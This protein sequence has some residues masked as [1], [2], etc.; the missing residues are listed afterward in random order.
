MGFNQ[1]QYKIALEEVGE[2]LSVGSNVPGI[3]Q[4]QEMSLH[5]FATLPST[6]QTLW[7][8]LNQGARHG[9]VVIAAQQT[10]GRGQWGRQWES[11]LGGLYLSVALTPQLQASNSAQLTMSSAWG[12]ATAL[13]SYDIPVALKWPNDLL[14]LGRKLGGIL[15]ETRVHQGEITKAVVGVGINWSNRVPE[16]GI[17]LQSFYETHLSTRVTSL[18]VLAAIVIQGLRLG[19]QRWLEQGIESLLPSYLEFLQIQGRQ[20]IVDGNPGIITGV[21]PI[22]DLRICLNSATAPTEICLK[23]GTIS[24]G[25]RW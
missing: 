7:D 23:P 9:T 6:N 10:A 5:L 11:T 12:I 20:V 21:T 18:E 24:L 19:Y 14:L 15:T 22:G 16:W 4:P 1:Q 17:T 13:R 25:Y 8:L 2:R 3:G